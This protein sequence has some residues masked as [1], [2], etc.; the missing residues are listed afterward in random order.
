MFLVA[1]HA[2]PS[3][4]R[5]RAKKWWSHAQA[6]I[7]SRCGQGTPVI[8]GIDAN[9]RLG[10]KEEPHCGGHQPGALDLSG[11]ALLQL[12]KELHLWAPQTYASSHR[13]EAWT[14]QSKRGDKHRVDYI[15]WPLAWC[16]SVVRSRVDHSVDISSGSIDH[17]L[18]VCEG[19][20]LG[21]SSQDPVTW[22]WAPL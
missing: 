10:K 20:A 6:I 13:G 8:I 17:S 4:D 18:V 22:R 7:K 16:S 19:V 21:S 14:W 2:P 11:K 5:G 3:K 9:G 15:L 12:C 1:A